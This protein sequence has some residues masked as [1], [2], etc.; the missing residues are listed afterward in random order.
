MQSVYIGNVSC[1]LLSAWTNIPR[2]GNDCCRRTPMNNTNFTALS[3]ATTGIKGTLSRLTIAF[4][5]MTSSVFTATFAEARITRIEIT[6]TESPT[7][8][9]MTFRSVGAYEKLRGRAYG[10]V[11][12][13][14]A[15][16]ALIT[17]VELAPRNANG[18]VEYS[19]DI[20]I[21]KPINLHSS[22]HKLFV[23]LPNRGNKLWDPFTCRA[24]TMTR[25]QRPTPV[26]LF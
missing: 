5:L 16:N 4:V 23:E 25:P 9:G 20:Y 22:N 13:A 26:R 15:R 6:S 2:F 11:D 10:E 7:F 14:D 1:L 19:M 24:G 8:E 3:H 18:Q 17:D 12:P 21:L